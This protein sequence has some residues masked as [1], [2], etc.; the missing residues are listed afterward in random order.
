MGWIYDRASQLWVH[1]GQ[2][3][4]KYQC[5]WNKDS[6]NSTSDK[7]TDSSTI[8][9]HKLS[10]QYVILIQWPVQ[11]DLWTQFCHTHQCGKTPCTAIPPQQPGS[12]N[13]NCNSTSGTILSH[14][15]SLTTNILSR[16]RG[17]I[18]QPCTGSSPAKPTDLWIHYWPI[19]R[20][21]EFLWQI[22]STTNASG[23]W[24]H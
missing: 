12:A 19:L 1:V 5:T 3:F 23:S 14:S 11:T 2:Q 7:C 9:V 22:T 10:S 16:L 20:W 13:Y 8:T 4:I 21:Y 18:L 6:L 17:Q 24:V 15:G